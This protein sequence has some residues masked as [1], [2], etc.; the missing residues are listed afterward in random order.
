MVVDTL[1]FRC[2]VLLEGVVTYAGGCKHIA[3]QQHYYYH[4]SVRIVVV[5]M[6]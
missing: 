5:V 6:Y 4:Y 2:S 3:Q 1:L